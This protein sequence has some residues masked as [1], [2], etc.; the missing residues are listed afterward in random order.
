M[1]IGFL[2]IVS[3]STPPNK[4]Y[5]LYVGS[6]DDA[7]FKDTQVRENTTDLEKFNFI[8]TGVGIFNCPD[9]DPNIHSIS[10][11]SHKASP[12]EIA[13]TKEEGNVVFTMNNG[14]LSDYVLDFGGFIIIEQMKQ[15]AGPGPK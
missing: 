12:S 9:F 5:V 2:P 1:S 14:V 8:R 4:R 3:S 11:T 15:L 10:L 7:G 13:Y 6:Q